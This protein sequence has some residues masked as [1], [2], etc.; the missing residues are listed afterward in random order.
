MYER[1]HLVAMR[2]GCTAVP[3]CG[4][5]HSFDDPVERLLATFLERFCDGL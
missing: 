5:S 4:F 2:T 3:F 1:V